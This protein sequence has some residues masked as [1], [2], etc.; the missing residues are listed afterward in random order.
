ML[1]TLRRNRKISAVALTAGSLACAVGL[2]MALAASQARGSSLAALSCGAQVSSSITLTSDIGPCSPSSDGL[3]IVASNIAVNLNGHTITGTN[4]TNNTLA[5][6]VG[7]GLMNVHGVTV[8]GPGAIQNFDAGITVNGGQGNKIAN[9][10][11]QN[12]VAHVLFSGGVDPTNLPATPC[13]NG[14][15]IVANNSNHNVISHVVATGNGPFSGIALVG[16]SNDNQVLH[17]DSFNNN[18]PNIIQTGAA[19]GQY[20]PCGPFGAVTVGPGRPN[21]DIGIRIEGPG[22]T[23]NVVNGNKAT[24]NMLEGIAIHGNICPG[25]PDVPPGLPN[26]HNLVE[27]NV[28]EHNG[29]GGPLDGIGVLSQGP[30]G[31]VYVAYDNS[32]VA[33]VSS[34]NANDGI[35]LGGRGSH[36]KCGAPQQDRLQRPRRNRAD[37]TFDRTESARHDQQRG[38]QQRGTRQRTE[39]RRR[40]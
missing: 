26:I 32:I 3:D 17:S 28:V 12:N 36:G 6:P 4:T 11:A 25:V 19:E 22:A 33:N 31:V 2:A 14:D 13:D 15:G 5:E 23:H 9:L 35:Y 29:F 38:S 8:T 1:R 7:I 18:V 40:R 27:H 10:T 34:Y 21:Q 20:G 37:R 16:A 39:R 24:G 30:P